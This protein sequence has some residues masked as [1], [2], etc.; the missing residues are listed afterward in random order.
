MITIIPYNEQQ[1]EDW[2]SF[3]AHNGDNETILF[4]RTFMD[5]H[6]ERF[7][8]C[9]IVAYYKN[10]IVAL[11]PANSNGS[12]VY[13]HSGLT[14]G[15]F[16][17]DRTLKAHIINL[18]VLETLKFYK[19]N[20]FQEVNLK[21]P[22]DFYS[23]STEIMEYLLFVLNA[24]QTRVDVA[25]CIPLSSKFNSKNYQKRR[26][27]AINKAIKLDVNVFESSDYGRFWN[28]VLEPNLV[29]KHGVKPVHTLDEI[30]SLVHSNAGKI[31]LFVA[32]LNSEIVSGVVCFE[33]EQ[34]VHAQYISSTPEGRSS[35]AIDLLFHTVIEKY[36]LEKEYFDFG[37]V[38]ENQGRAVNKGLLEWK[39]GFASSPFCHKFYS[40]DTN[41]YT[42][43]EQ[44]DI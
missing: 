20:G 25:Y 44:L 10:K 11:F 24:T 22:P 7:T 5:Y 2:D 43:L 19:T 41:N 40:I 16:I 33:S 37:I 18:I 35:G 39:E 32:E 23:A 14:F 36:A 21:L 1:L 26:Q 27:R 30:N 9:S 8:D 31:K 6:K 42:L 34:V 13:S 38:N 12:A 4:Y 29:A 3:L 17:F 15:G 28:E